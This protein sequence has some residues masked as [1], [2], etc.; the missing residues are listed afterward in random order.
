MI[1][2]RGVTKLYGPVIGI[3]DVS[4]ELRPGSYGLLGPNGSG[5]T[6]MINLIIGQLRPTIGRVRLF[7][8]NPWRHGA[9]LSRVGLCPAHEALYPNVTGYQWVRHLTRLHGF[10][11]PGLQQR[12]E[13]SLELVRMT[14]AMHRP[15]RTYSLGMRQRCKLA[16]A[17]AHHPE[18]LILDEPFNGLDPLGRIEMTRVLKQWVAD[19]RSLILASHILHEVEAVDPS[20]LLISGGR[21]LASGSP[22]EVRSILASCPN[23]VYVRSSNGHRLASAAVALPSVEAIKFDSENRDGVLITT[24]QP[25]D[26]MKN[27]PALAEADGIEIHEV[28][29]ADDSLQDIFTMLMRIHRGEI[30]A[31]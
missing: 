18:L 20:L 2:L 27:L 29:P 13:Q 10:S 14:H 3:N 15:M 16:Q 22:T 9:L 24:R 7:G 26:L 12:V 19:G 28:R 25:L 5:K 21:L 30:A 17:I 6:T 8:E 31:L 1:E 23:V 4:L 11:G